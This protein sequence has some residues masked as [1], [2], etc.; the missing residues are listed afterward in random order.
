MRLKLKLSKNKI[1]VPFE[2]QHK[3]AGTIHKWFGINEEHGK[4]SVFSFSQ[5][6]NGE[7]IEKG[8]NFPRGSTLYFSSSDNLLLTNIYKGIKAD[9]TL[10]C[11]LKVYEIDILPEPAFRNRERFSLLSP[12][13][14]KQTKEGE[15]KARHFTFEDTETEELLT[16][17]VKRRLEKNGIPDSA[18][19]ITFDKSYSGKKTKVIKYKGIGNKTSVCPI[20]VEGKFTTM[21]FLWNNGVGHSTGI[22]FGCLK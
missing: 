5:L 17:A 13:F 8:F 10:F 3:L 2:Y 9:P 6:Q 4:Q 11:G 14:F 21:E 7:V 20:I 19:K 12:L 22:G 15:R 18:L 16:N 1:T